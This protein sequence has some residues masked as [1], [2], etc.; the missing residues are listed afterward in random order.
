MTRKMSKL[1]R[2]VVMSVILLATRGARGQAGNESLPIAAGDML[3]I[4][5]LE[6][7]EL[8]EH[9]RVTDQGKVKLLI[10]GEVLVA[11]KTPA[12]AAAAIE[13][14]LVKGQYMRT[15]QVL[16]TVDEYAT[17]NISVFG[18][19]KTPG[20]Y[21]ARTIR[22]VMEAVSLAQGLLETADR[23]VVIERRG[24]KEKVSYYLSND[25]NAL[26]SD[27]IEVYPG[28]TVIVPRAPVVY[29]MGDVLQASGYAISTP[30]SKVSLLQLVSRA[31]STA[32]TAAANSSHIIR[33]TPEGGSVDIAV[34]LGDIRTGKS[35]DIQLQPND[36]VYIPFSFLRNFALGINTL[37]GAVSGLA[38]RSY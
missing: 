14:T 2:V 26:P 28:D 25:P 8:E 32:K 35:P 15:P 17:L 31:G 19:V 27:Q 6:T 7:P 10:G 21:Q 38:V 33:K 16:V 18:E 5:V 24:S 36:V 3:H 20:V 30:D 13:D 34:K 23:H 9:A 11:G 12:E 22:S 4:Q 29:I 1:K 37:G